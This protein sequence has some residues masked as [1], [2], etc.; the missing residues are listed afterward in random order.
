MVMCRS[1]GR[2]Y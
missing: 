2:M 1:P